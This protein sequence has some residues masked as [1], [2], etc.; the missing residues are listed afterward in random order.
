MSNRDKRIRR[1]AEGR[2]IVIHGSTSTYTNY[3]CHCLPCTSARKA[4]D[5]ARRTTPRPVPGA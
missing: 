1:L 3:G 5:A 4:Y 2:I